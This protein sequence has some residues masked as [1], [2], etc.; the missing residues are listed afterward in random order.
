[1][2]GQVEGRRRAAARVASLSP[3]T[4]GRVCCALC[5]AAGLAALALSQLSLGSGACYGRARAADAVDADL[6]TAAT[7][8]LALFGARSNTVNPSLA[9]LAPSSASR[10]RRPPA[11]P[12]AKTPFAS[13]DAAL[14]PATPPR[15]AVSALASVYE[16]SACPRARMSSSASSASRARPARAHTETSA[17]HTAAFG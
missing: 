9:S 13:D 6:E 15:H 16:S 4:M 10:R 7:I 12:V 5:P 14:A 1:M 11:G 8:P 17:L 3:Y 2:R